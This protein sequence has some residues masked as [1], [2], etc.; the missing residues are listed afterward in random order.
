[1]TLPQKISNQIHIFVKKL[2]NEDGK[3][4]LPF[5]RQS[6]WRNKNENTSQAWIEQYHRDINKSHIAEETLL[7]SFYVSLV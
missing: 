1:M 4:D 3:V 2:S 5:T 6:G 7:I